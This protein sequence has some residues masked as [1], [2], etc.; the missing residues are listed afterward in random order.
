MYDFLSARQVNESVFKFQFAAESSDDSEFKFD[1]DADDANSG[2]SSTSSTSSDDESAAES[3]A[4]EE[5]NADEEV[6]MLEKFCIRES[7]VYIRD[8]LFLTVTFTSNNDLKT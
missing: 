5:P 8:L 2:G 4:E 3:E 7:G 6:R 1:E